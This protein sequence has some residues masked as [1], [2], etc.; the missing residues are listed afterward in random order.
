M[1]PRETPLPSWANALALMLICSACAGTVR[2]QEDLLS[3]NELPEIQLGDEIFNVSNS[4]RDTGNLYASTVLVFNSGIPECSGVLIH[5]RLVLTAG[6]CVCA[7]REDKDT[8]TLDNSACEKT[9][10]ISAIAY[11][12][13]T[14]P[15]Y[16]RNYTGTVSVHPD[17]KAVLK[18]KRLRVPPGAVINGIAADAGEH[19]VVVHT[20]QESQ[21]DLALISLEED[22][23]FLFPAVPPARTNIRPHEPVVVVGYGADAVKNRL[24]SFTDTQPTRRFGKNLITQRES[25]KF[26]IE[27]PGSLALPGDSGGPCFRENGHG[28]TLIGINSRS[29][30]G[31]KSTFTSTYHYLGWLDAEIQR[32]DQL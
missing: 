22:A 16:S 18:K 31:K 5:R 17:F 15:P 1:N 9:T 11:S 20:V 3:V 26:T 6:H 21:A 27:A 10:T 13:P 24:V 7:G 25:E 29:S 28:L 12:S 2:P 4:N 32:V 14:R 8:I 23:E 19:Y 30:P